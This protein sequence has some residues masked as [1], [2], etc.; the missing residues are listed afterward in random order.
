MAIPD[1]IDKTLPLA[2]GGRAAQTEPFISEYNA[3]KAD[4]TPTTTGA[5]LQ[6][7]NPLLTSMAARYDDSPNLKGQAKLLALNAFDTYD[8]AKGTLRNHLISHLSGLQ[9]QSA[10]NDQIISIPERIVIDQSNLRNAEKELSDELG[11]D[12]T[13][14]ELANHSGVPL[15]RIGYIRK[16]R[17]AINSSRFVDEAGE[18]YSPASAIPENNAMADVWQNIVYHDLSPTDQLIMEHSLGLRGKPVLENRALASKLGISAGAVS[19]R[20]A[21]IQQALDERFQH[22][23]FGE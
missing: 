6:A 17:H 1:Y 18:Q 2:S 11:R 12:P 13:D 5:L 20:K 22:T 9:R 10:K 19:Q 14:I 23:V 15:K 21:K 4:R 7:V 8:P 3:W 16:A